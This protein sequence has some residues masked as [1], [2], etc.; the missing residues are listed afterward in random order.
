MVNDDSLDEM[1]A[2]RA[3]ANPANPANPAFPALL[4]D[5]VQRR[6]AE[7]GPFT[8]DAPEAK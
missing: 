8:D 1:I 6:Q 3:S 4:D 2:Q 5:A 7:T